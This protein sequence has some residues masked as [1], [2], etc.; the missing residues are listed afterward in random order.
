[1]DDA[2]D[3]III[4]LPLFTIKWSINSLVVVFSLP[5]YYLLKNA[6]ARNQST[7]AAM[8]VYSS[9]KENNNNKTDD[10]IP[11]S[12]ALQDLQKLSNSLQAQTNDQW[13]RVNETWAYVHDTEQASKDYSARVDSTSEQK[14]VRKQ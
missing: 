3:A 2:S 7:M 5:P 9:P 6:A 4:K 11:L 8:G 14:I 13:K 10:P 1:M 12:S